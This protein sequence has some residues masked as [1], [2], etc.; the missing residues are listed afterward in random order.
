MKLLKNFQC[1]CSSCITL[2]VILVLLS[3]CSKN[4]FDRGSKDNPTE[5]S[6][7]KVYRST[8]EMADLA[9]INTDSM[10]FVSKTRS[11]GDKEISVFPLLIDGETSEIYV[12][13]NYSDSTTVFTTEYIN[14]PAEIL[15]YNNSIVFDDTTDF[16]DA[17]DVL[18]HMLRRINNSIEIFSSDEELLTT[19]SEI[20][21][22]PETRLIDDDIPPSSEPTETYSSGEYA[23]TIYNSGVLLNTN[24]DQYYP[25]NYTLTQNG[26]TNYPIGCVTIA[27]GQI[28]KFHE[29]P[30]QLTTGGV[31]YNYNL[32]P[33]YY[34]GISL[35]TQQY[36]A[37][38]LYELA[39]L[40]NTNYASGG[41]SSDNDNIRNTIGL[42]YDFQTEDVDYTFNTITTDLKTSITNN[43][44]IIITA[45]GD[46]SGHAW[47]IDGYNNYQICE[48]IHELWYEDGVLIF[49]NIYEEVL[50]SYTYLHH[51]AGWGGRGDVWISTVS[52]VYLNGSKYND[53]KKVFFL[54]PK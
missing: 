31:I 50:R 33:N 10:I 40:L 45:D 36:T 37:P 30:S 26:Y 7:T 54:Q 8:D 42:Y 44:P 19:A 39:E 14:Y 4:V 48:E 43:R 24:W 20:T 2:L 6:S 53:D 15:A 16:E 25:Y 12:V 49:Q 5:E 29:H 47:V 32:M 1:Y 52:D 35:F 28:F 38:F 3:A 51:N 23:K 11:E 41:S 21:T 46:V 22:I 34:D 17:P 18:K 27:V 9:I 13:V